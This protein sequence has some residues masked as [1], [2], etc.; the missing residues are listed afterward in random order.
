[1]ECLQVTIDVAEDDPITEIK[2]KLA[3]VTGVPPEHQ[4]ILLGGISQ[5]CMGDK[6]TSIRFGTC[7][8][9]HPENEDDGVKL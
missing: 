4:R 3:K 1:M 9:T 6:R 5:M 8:V 7:G 2:K